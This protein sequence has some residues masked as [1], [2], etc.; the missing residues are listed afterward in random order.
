MQPGEVLSEAWALYKAHWRHFLPLA[1][2]V[3]LAI[4]LI[5]LVLALLLGWIGAVFATLIGFVGIFWL[6]GALCEAVADVRD[7]RADLSLSDTLQKV[8]PRVAPLLGAGV[9]AGLGVALGLILLIVPG[10]ILLTWWSLIV[11]VIVLERVAA[12]DSFGRSRAL[13]RGNGWNVSA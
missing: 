4:S 8:R 13:V 7:G 10:L 12:T 1:F 2:V 5:S 3:F 11:P 9:L 6:Q